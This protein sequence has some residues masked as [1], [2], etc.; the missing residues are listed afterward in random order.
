MSRLIL[1]T[2]L[3]GVATEFWLGVGLIGTQTH[4][5]QKFSF[6]SDSATLFLKC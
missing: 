1:P 4:L 6:S 5:P 3:K 2:R